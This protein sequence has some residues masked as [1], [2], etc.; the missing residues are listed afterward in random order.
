[1]AFLVERRAAA[2]AGRERAAEEDLRIKAPPHQPV[3]GALRDREADVERVAERI[4]ALALRERLVGGA[5][6]QRVEGLA[7]GPGTVP[8]RVAGAQQSEV[9]QDVELQDD[10]RRLAPVGG[11]VDEVVLVGLERRLGDDVEVGDDMALR[12]DQEARADRGL[13]GAAL[14]HRADL[15]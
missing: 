9:V 11:D 10:E 13:A 15:H 5:K 3:V 6:R 1:M 12:R 7:R 8:T 4:D 2:H 14:Q